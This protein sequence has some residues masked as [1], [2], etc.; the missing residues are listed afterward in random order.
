MKKENTRVFFKKKKN[1]DLKTFVF[2]ITYKKIRALVL[3]RKMAKK[4]ILCSC[5]AFGFHKLPAANLW[6]S[7]LHICQ[8]LRKVWSVGQVWIL[9]NG[10]H[11]ETIKC[12]RGIR[13]KCFCSGRSQWRPKGVIVGL[14]NLSCHNSN[15]RCWCWI[16]APSI[17]WR[18]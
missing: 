5:R 12:Q 2:T 15:L 14:P 8:S 1:K 4:K 10:C 9:S 16:R 11:M 18:K 13:D 6:S 3:N 17:T 7:R